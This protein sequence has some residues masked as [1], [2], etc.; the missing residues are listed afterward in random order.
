M[1]NKILKCGHIPN[2]VTYIDGEEKECCA[3]CGC[4]E[5][6]DIEVDLTNRKAKCRYCDNETKSNFNLPFF[7]YKPNQE[8]DNY[9][10]G[11]FGWD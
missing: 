6:S 9:Y 7:E 4:Y 11:C 10:C 5:F 1:C 2:S 8:Y 3:I